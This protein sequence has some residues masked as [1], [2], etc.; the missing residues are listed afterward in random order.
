MNRTQI[1]LKHSANAENKKEAAQK[2]SIFQP[3]LLM[4]IEASG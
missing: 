2:C 4:L 1:R 3:S